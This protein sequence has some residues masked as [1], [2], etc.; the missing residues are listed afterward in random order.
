MF[1]IGDR[2]YIDLNMNNIDTFLFDDCIDEKQS[3]NTPNSVCMLF[4]HLSIY[5]HKY[6]YITFFLL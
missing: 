3:P 6:I 1:N 2:V 5:T 4:I